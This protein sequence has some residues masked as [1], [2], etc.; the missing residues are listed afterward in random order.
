ME[1]EA[2][3]ALPGRIILTGPKHAGKSAAA[4]ALARLYRTG[5]IDLDEL[6]TRQSGKSPRTLYQ[7]GPEVFRKAETLA[8]ETLLKSREKAVIAA[9]GGIVD[10]GEAAALLE[11]AEGLIMV[12]LEVSAETAWQRIAAQALRDGGLP[13]F[14]DTPQPRETHRV[15]HERRAEA[16]RNRAHLTIRAE[17]KSP[18]EIAREISQALAAMSLR[19]QARTIGSTG[20]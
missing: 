18:E 17:G 6:I 2:A 13:P 16:Y 9:G 5:C 1:T 7:E 10:N 11:K 12:Y 4:A 15:L 19:G 3:P 14:L 20:Y 8:L